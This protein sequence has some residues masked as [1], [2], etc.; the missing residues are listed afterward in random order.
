MLQTPAAAEGK[1]TK[2]SENS[3]S[4]RHFTATFTL[5]LDFKLYLLPVQLADDKNPQ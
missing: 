4:L 1:S 3:I 5:R 2:N